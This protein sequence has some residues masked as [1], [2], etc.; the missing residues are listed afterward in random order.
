MMGW[1]QGEIAA[2]NAIRPNL[3]PAK[4]LV[5]DDDERTR[6]MLHGFLMSEGHDCVAI[7]N[8]AEAVALCKSTHFDCM[9]LDVALEGLSGLAVAQRLGGSDSVIRP[10]C[11]FLISGRPKSDFAEAIRA[12]WADGHLLKPI[13]SDELAAAV[14]GS[15]RAK[16]PDP[17][18]A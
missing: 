6:D 11:V 10:A 7:A 2:L 15:V 8:G 4:V 3:P 14:R 16:L 9:L 13:A 1:P 18:G 5:V 17:Q 12:G